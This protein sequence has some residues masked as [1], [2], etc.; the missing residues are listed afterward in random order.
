MIQM[1]VEASAVLAKPLSK[2]VELEMMQWRARYL[3]AVTEEVAV[4][5]FDSRR[6]TCH[7]LLFNYWIRCGGLQAFLALFP[8]ACRYLWD[9]AGSHAALEAAAAHTDS[10]SACYHPL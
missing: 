2:E 8:L 9:L 6:G 1:Q 3:R 4:V 7:C 10:K 5:L